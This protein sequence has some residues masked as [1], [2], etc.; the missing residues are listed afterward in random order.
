MRLLILILILPLSFASLEITEISYSEDEWFEIFNYNNFIVNLSAWKI[1]DNKNTDKIECCKDNCSLIAEPWQYILVVGRSSK[2]IN[3]SKEKLLCVDD[4]KIGNGLGN[5]N[6]LLNLSNGNYSYLVTYT[7]QLG[8]YK[9]NKTLEKREDGTWGESIVDNGTPWARNSIWETSTEYSYLQISEFLPSPK[10]DDN[11]EKPFG[12]WVEILNIGPKDIVISGLKLTDQNIENELYVANSNLLQDPVLCAGCYAVI[13]RN[14]DTDFSLNN[15]GYDEVNLNYKDEVIDKVSYTGSTEDMS[16]S[17]VNENWYQT[18]PTPGSENNYHGKC[19]WSISISSDDLIKSESF[20]FAITV[21]REYGFANNVTVK[22]VVE[23]YYGNTIKEYRPWSN[24]YIVNSASKKYSPNFKEGVYQIKLWIENI[25]CDTNLEN[26]QINEVFSVNPY[27]TTNNNLL[28]IVKIST[29]KGLGWGDQF[30][31]KISVYKGNTTKKVVS[32]WAEKDDIKITKTSKISVENNYQNYVFTIP[33]QLI[34]NCAKEQVQDGTGIL[35]VQGFGQKITQEFEIKGIK[36]KVCKDYSKFK[37]RQTKALLRE[38]AKESLQIIGLPTEVKSGNSIRFKL[39][40]FDEKKR[41]Y[42][43]WSYFY[44]GNKC[45]SCLAAERDGNKIDFHVDNELKTVELINKIDED[46][47]TGWYKLMVKILHEDRKTPKTITQNIYVTK[48]L[49]ITKYQLNQSIMVATQPN[50]T[51]KISDI[52]YDRD[53]IV[54]PESKFTVYQ[55]SSKLIQRILPI[56]LAISFG[57]ML[58]F[59]GFKS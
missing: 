56:F 10:G 6:D 31:A 51:E 18:E 5:S 39:Q 43:A 46:I 20:D 1:Q 3:D 35:I 17:L 11:A 57:T 48:A 29:G 14:G 22:G 45:Y 34:S 52:S 8:A 59:Y 58:I 23:D 30:T 7:K 28:N 32:I 19:D 9:N 13:Y 44:R 50:K 38:K 25:T 4:A 55:S 27:H 36:S 40:L 15:Y 21:N 47:A 53:K 49:N 26:N 54:I 2:L 42:Q 41:K 37:E 12:E 33:L 16:W 24:Q